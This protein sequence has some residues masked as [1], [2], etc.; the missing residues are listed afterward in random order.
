MVIQEEKQSPKEGEMGWLTL[1]SSL[2]S[3]LFSPTTLTSVEAR[4]SLVH[5]RKPHLVLV[6]KFL[7][8]CVFLFNLGL[9]QSFAH[10]LTSPSK[11][12]FGT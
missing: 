2:Y 5:D 8:F 4:N 9:D 10:T 7:I 1:A 3:S 11:A 12:K 6:F